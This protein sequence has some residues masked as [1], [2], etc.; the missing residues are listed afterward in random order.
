MNIITDYFE[1]HE[2]QWDNVVGFCT[3]GAPAMVGSRSGLAT[4]VKQKNPKVITTHCMIHRQALA[5]KTLSEYLLSVL[6]TSI[7]IVNFVKRSALNTRLF[8]QLCG[9][10]EAEHDALIFHTEVRWLS[11]GIYWHVYLS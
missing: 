11:K 1:K 5:S 10:L 2:L 6:K 7:N 4:L 9:E 8:K 3:D